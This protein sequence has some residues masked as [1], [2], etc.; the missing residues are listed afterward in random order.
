MYVCIYCIAQ[1]Q[2][3]YRGWVGLYKIVFYFE[4]F[5]H[6]S[7]IL[8][9][10]PS[11]C[12]RSYRATIRARKKLKKVHALSQKENT[13]GGGVRGGTHKKNIFRRGTFPGTQNPWVQIARKL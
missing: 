13:G 1:P 6:E 2:E 11:T 9:L 10:P 5:V 12:L 8:L 3:R 7:I 4:T